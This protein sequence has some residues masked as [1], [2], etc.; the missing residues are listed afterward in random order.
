MGIALWC[1]LS[2]I[3][4]PLIL[5]GMARLPGIT[6]EKN[7]YPRITSDSFTDYKQ[8]LYWAHQNALEAVAPFCAAVIIAQYMNVEQQTINA[9]A[10]AFVAF[11]ISHALMYVA[12]KGLLRSIMFVGGTACVVSLLILAA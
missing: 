10:L 3:M 9:L 5:A 2:V 8:R 4:L 11:R 12:N 1:V 7:L 6:L